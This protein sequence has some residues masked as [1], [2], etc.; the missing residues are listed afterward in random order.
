M[1]TFASSGVVLAPG[2]SMVVRYGENGFSGPC[3]IPVSEITATADNPFVISVTYDVDVE[4]N[5][6]FDLSQKPQVGPTQTSRRS[7]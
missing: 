5:K 6:Y 7:P 4:P 3:P 2:G 1:Q